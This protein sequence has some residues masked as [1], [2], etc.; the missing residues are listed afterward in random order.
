[1]ERAHR[2]RGSQIHHCTMGDGVRIVCNARVRAIASD[3]RTGRVRAVLTDEGA[4]HLADLVVVGVGVTAVA[5]K[6]I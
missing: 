6:D 1:M 2:A 4:E 5:V 3:P